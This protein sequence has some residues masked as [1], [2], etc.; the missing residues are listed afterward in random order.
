V[1]ESSR[2]YDELHAVGYLRQR[3]SFYR[4]LV[5]LLHARR[6]QTLLDV[7]CGQGPLVHFA[8]KAGL[9]AV[10]LDLSPSAIAIAARQVPSALISVADAEQLP[11]AD[12]TFDY[13]TN[14]GSIEH[15]F[16]PHLAVREMARVLHPDGLALILLPNTFGLLGNVLHVWRRGDV[17]DDGQPLQ[18]YGTYAQWRRLLELNG[19]YVAKTIKYE[20]E[21]PRTW[22]DLLWYMMRPYKLGRAL[23]TPLIPTNL[24]SHLVFLCRKT[25]L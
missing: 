15:Y 17:F 4:W 24:T 1:T 12:N 14:I 2:N 20:R 5:S 7:S 25:S 23:L 8:L 21:W 6:G 18:R 19:L 22:E 11:Y 13:A 16:H 9:R 10:G 3:D